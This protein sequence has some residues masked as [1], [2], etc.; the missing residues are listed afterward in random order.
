MCPTASAAKIGG[1]DSSKIMKKW[2]SDQR[3]S[4]TE[5]QHE[6][7]EAEHE[8]SNAQQLLQR[9]RESNN[10]LMGRLSPCTT[11]CNGLEM[12]NEHL[13]KELLSCKANLLKANGMLPQIRKEK[14]KVSM[15]KMIAGV[16]LL[17]LSII[18]C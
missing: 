1:P 4:R 3:K 10:H 13:K 5:A 12:Q 11:R 18:M 14:E 16:V 17:I 6:K 9:E 7:L 15:L 2:W 8:R